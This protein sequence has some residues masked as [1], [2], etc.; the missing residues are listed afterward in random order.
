MDAVTPATSIP[1]AGSDCLPI[2]ATGTAAGSG[3]VLRYRFVVAVKVSEGPGESAMLCC[4]GGKSTSTSAAS[5]A[6]ARATRP[7]PYCNTKRG[8]L[9]WCHAHKPR[10]HLQRRPLGVRVARR[11]VGHVS[12]SPVRRDEV[13]HVHYRP[14]DEYRGR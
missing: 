14:V 9:L 11:R 12:P 13:L 2:S 7:V 5:A 4:A 1:A 10:H 8:H 6:T 3:L